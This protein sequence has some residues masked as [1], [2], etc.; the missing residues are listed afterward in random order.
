ML[1]CFYRYSYTALN[2]TRVADVELDN[3]RVFFLIKHKFPSV[4]TMIYLPLNLSMFGK[5]FSIYFCTLP[6]PLPHFY[7][8]LTLIGLGF[9]DSSQFGGGGGFRPPTQHNF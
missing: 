4:G 3:G 8:A 5:V 1:T 9:F 7:T 6:P 2:I